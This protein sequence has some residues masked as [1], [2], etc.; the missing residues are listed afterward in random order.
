MRN[1]RQNFFSGFRYN[2]LGAPI[3][4]GVLNFFSELCS[5]NDR[6]RGNEFQFGV[7][8]WKRYVCVDCDYN[9]FLIALAWSAPLRV[10]ALLLARF[11]APLSATQT[12]RSIRGR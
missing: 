1:I 3:A 8:D 6:G 11:S 10:H 2:A 5:A 4:A 9:S 12:C 7:R